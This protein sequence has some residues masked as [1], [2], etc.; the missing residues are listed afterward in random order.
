M[1]GRGAYELKRRRGAVALARPVPQPGIRLLHAVFLALA[2]LLALLALPR[3]ADAAPRSSASS[4]A[5]RVYLLRGL[6]NIF[7]LGM[8]DLAAKLKANGVQ[9]SVHAYPDWEAIAASEQ[10]V[11]G[12]RPVIVIGHSL[13]AD[14]AVNLGNRLAATGVSVPLVVTFDPI[15][16]P[17]VSPRIGRVV[18]YFQ[19]T[20]EGKRLAGR[21]VRNVDVSGPDVDHFNIDKQPTLHQQVI[22]MIVGSGKAV[23]RSRVKPRSSAGSDVAKRPV[24]DV[25]A[26]AAA[27]PAAG[28]APIPTAPAP[29]ASVAGARL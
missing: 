13:G 25:P 24:A 2:L 4:A 29:T 19:G 23:A 17:G 26:S 21:T 11:G 15:T 16:P 18:N 7:S 27:Q 14:A 10:A 8:D 9:A 5:P 6:A 28:T 3:P 12:R 20:G 1:I 22:A